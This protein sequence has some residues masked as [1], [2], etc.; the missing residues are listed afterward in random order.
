MEPTL[1]EIDIFPFN[2]CP[3][4]WAECVGQ[5]LKIADYAELFTLLGTK[6]GGDGITTFGLPD[7]RCASLFDSKMKYFIALHGYFPYKE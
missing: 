7:M 3:A 1:G 2:H 5:T 6:F 4:K